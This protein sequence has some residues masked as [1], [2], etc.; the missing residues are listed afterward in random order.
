M[1][2]ADESKVCY[3]SHLCMKQTKAK[4]VMYLIYVI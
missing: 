3:V 4:S 2:E 1:H